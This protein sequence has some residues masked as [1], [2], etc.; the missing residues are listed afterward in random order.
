MAKSKDEKR[1]E[2]A[3]ALANIARVFVEKV[4]RKALADELKRLAKES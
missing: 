2:A 3:E 1:A 4:D